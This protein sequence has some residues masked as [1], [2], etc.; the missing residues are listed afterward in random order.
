MFKRSFSQAAVARKQLSKELL[1]DVKFQV[2]TYARPNDLCITRGANA[3]LYDD[4]SGKEFIDFTAGIAVTALGHSNPKVAEILAQQASKLVHSSN[5][6]YTAEC[7]RLSEKIVENTKRFGGQHDASRVFLCNSGTEANE[8]ALKFAKKHGII[9]DHKKQGIVAFQNSF[10]G[11]TMGALS[12]TWNSKYRTPFG[13]LLPNVTFLNVNDQLT[14]LQD[15]IQSKS[16][17]L[18]GLIVEPIQG[19]GGVF[20]IPVE[21]LVGLKKICADNGIAVIYD[22]IQCGMGRSGKLWAHSYLPKEA[23]PDIFTIAKALGNGFPIAATV[24]NEKI[25]NALQVGDHGTTYGGNPL[26]CAVSNYVLDTICQDSFLEEVNKKSEILVNRLQKIQ[27]RFPDHIREVRGKGLMI[28]ADFT[29]AP[30]AVVAKARDLGLLVI[31]AGK[32][33]VRFVP[34]LTIEDKV[35]E[36]GLDVFEKAVESV[37][38]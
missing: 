20:P 24:V 26:G 19:E 10:H 25:N 30:G 18:A 11:R 8:A 3:K 35:L 36:Q 4:F 21:T 29:E 6:Y 23:H 7:L 2:T 28:G 34:A 37:F 12:V 15:V 1:D 13:D 17:E 14:K 38:A 22:E 31:T 27:K 9:Q 32:T 16:T 33:T 5:L